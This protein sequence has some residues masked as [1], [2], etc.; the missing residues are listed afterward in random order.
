MPQPPHRL[1]TD[2]DDGMLLII[3]GPSG[4]GKTTITRAVERSIP[5]AVF[6]V[7]ATTR[8]KTDADAEGIDYHFVDDAEFERMKAAGEFLECAGIYGRKYG[9]PR[10]WVQEQLRRGRLVILEIDVQGAANVKRLIPDA[11]GIFIL[12]PGEDVLLQR[13]RSRRR[14]DEAT[15]QRRFTSAQNEIAAARAGGVYNAF[16]TNEK[17]EDAI[18]RA[19]EL[20]EA[21]RARRRGR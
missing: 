3:S 12:P 20:V 21:E 4:V 16:I 7:S 1:P 14:E 8:P 15:I 5:D 11:Y 6:S 10:G 18:A 13:L 17:L 19:V 9:T 2:T